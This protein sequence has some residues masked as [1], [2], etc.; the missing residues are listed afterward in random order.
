[1]N[2]EQMSSSFSGNK[3]KF[4]KIVV[5]ENIED[6]GKCHPKRIPMTTRLDWLKRKLVNGDSEILSD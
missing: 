2:C 4:C 1:M 3:S 6:N 5:F